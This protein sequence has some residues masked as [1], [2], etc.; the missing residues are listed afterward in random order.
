MFG[1]LMMELLA[2]GPSSSSLFI[3]EIEAKAGEGHG[4]GV[5]RERNTRVWKMEV[6]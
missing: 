6:V 4:L 3:V 5:S 2:L 1:Y